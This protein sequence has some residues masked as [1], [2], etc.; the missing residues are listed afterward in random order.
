M[1]SSWQS[2]HH[3]FEE[4]FRNVEHR[5]FVDWME[6]AAFGAFGEF[7]ADFVHKVFDDDG[8]D[9]VAVEVKRVRVQAHFL[10][11]VEELCFGNFAGHTFVGP[12]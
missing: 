2:A 3:F 9:R 7:F 5:R 10:R 6:F 4:I 8:I 11:D 12:E 1:L